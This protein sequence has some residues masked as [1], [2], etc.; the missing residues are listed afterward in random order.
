MIEPYI[1]LVQI[2]DEICLAENIVMVGVNELKFGQKESL[3]IFVGHHL[4]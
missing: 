4:F 3:S 1:L 2:P